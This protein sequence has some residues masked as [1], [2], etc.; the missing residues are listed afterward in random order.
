MRARAHCARGVLLENRDRYAAVAEYK[1]ARELA[2]QD[3]IPM[4]LYARG[5]LLLDP[6]QSQV[7][8]SALSKLNRWILLKLIRIK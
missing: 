1:K 5:A 4:F 7:D 3:A 8:R 2:P 6:S